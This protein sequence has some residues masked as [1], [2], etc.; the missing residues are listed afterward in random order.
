MTID[1]EPLPPCPWCKTAKKVYKHGERD[2]VC[3]GC[4]RIFDG[5][6]DGEIGYG[7]PEKYAQ[8]NER[9]QGRNAVRK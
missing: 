4:K 9:R 2:F 8:R 5:I 1:T 3:L 6:D 7:R